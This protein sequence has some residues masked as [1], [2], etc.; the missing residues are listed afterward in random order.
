[1][2]LRRQLVAV[3]ELLQDL[4]VGARAGLR[5]L[6]DRQVQLV[7]QDRLELLR[8]ADVERPAGDRVDV[9]LDAV[10]PLRQLHAL[11]GEFLD[12]D[13]HAVELHVGEHADQRPLQVPVEIP[14]V[15]LLEP[16]FEQPGELPGDVGV[17]GGVLRDPLDLDLEHPLLLFPLLAD[18]GR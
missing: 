8:A 12:V 6:D 9:G 7:E 13:P 18:S 16:A 10:E 1:M 2:N 14:E 5:P 17:L 3:G 4:D 15:F 11:P